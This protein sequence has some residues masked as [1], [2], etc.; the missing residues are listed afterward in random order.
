LKISLALGLCDP[1]DL[2]DCVIE[3]DLLKEAV[4]H[5]PK[6]NANGTITFEW[7]KYLFYLSIMI[8]VELDF[9]T[10]TLF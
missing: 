3:I 10:T 1:V 5:F 9:R 2:D 8:S 6:L 4:F 7:R